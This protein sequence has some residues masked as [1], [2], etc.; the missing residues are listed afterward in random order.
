MDVDDAGWRRLALYLMITLASVFAPGAV[1][2]ASIAIWRMTDD[3][4]LLNTLQS[5]TADDAGALRYLWIAAGVSLSYLVGYF[6]RAIGFMTVRAFDKRWKRERTISEVR[7]DIMTR[8]GADA[9]NAA[10]SSHPGLRASLDDPADATRLGDEKLFDAFIYCKLWLRRMAPSL[11]IDAIELEIN[12]LCGSLLP[13]ISLFF[14]AGA[15]AKFSVTLWIGAGLI[16]F[17]LCWV[18]VWNARKLMADERYEAF[19]NIVADTA[20]RNATALSVSP[21]S[22]TAANP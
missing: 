5:R 10:M 16:G 22:S 17:L 21:T 9:W 19:R 3:S 15:Q 2:V 7:N 6:A 11:N 8:F 1:I 18:I 4:E 14:L 20:M 12:V 13:A